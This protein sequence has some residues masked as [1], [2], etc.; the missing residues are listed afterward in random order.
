[1]FKFVK[2]FYNLLLFII[3]TNCCLLFVISTG[4]CD[5]KVSKLIENISPVYI[6]EQNHLTISINKDENKNI[7]L[8]CKGVHSLVLKKLYIACDNGKV[9]VYKLED[10][11][12]PKLETTYQFEGRIL[13][14]FLLYDEIWVKLERVTAQPLTMPTSH[15][16]LVVSEKMEAKKKIVKVE[17]TKKIEKSIKKPEIKVLKPASGKVLEVRTGSVVINFGIKSGLVINDKV[18]FYNEN[19]IDLGGSQKTVEKET[20]AIGKVTAVSINRAQVML[21]IDERVNVGAF[22]V[23][24]DKKITSG[25]FVTPRLHDITEYSL[26][27]RPFL[28]LGTMGFGTVSDFSVTYRFQEPVFLKLLVN[29]IGIGLAEQGNIV[30]LAANLIVGY[31]TKLFEIG[32]GLGQSAINDELGET[33]YKEENDSGGINTDFEN[34]KSG[35]SLAQSIRLGSLDG[36]NFSLNNTFIL[37]NDKFNYGGSNGSLQYPVGKKTWIKVAGG[38]GVAGYW[39]WEIALKVLAYGNGDRGSLFVTPSLGMAG[40]TGDLEDKNDNNYTDQERIEYSGP[41]VG[42]ALEWRK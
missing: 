14:L 12:N 37:Y 20:I 2:K 28:A 34:V 23:K 11:L 17:K 19:T 22:A 41:M 10:P 7:V 31:D 42:I 16:V 6:L 18:R 36:F 1:M 24:T 39:F 26:S 3:I 5:G 27:F 8:D 33:N 25:W 38:G 13:E 15:K 29:P 30:S 40:L 35:L 9:N 4:F 21:G 32:L